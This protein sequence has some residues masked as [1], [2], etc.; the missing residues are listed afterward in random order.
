MGNFKSLDIN[1][2]LNDKLLAHL[3]S[4]PSLFLIMCQITLKVVNEELGRISIKLKVASYNGIVIICR[5]VYVCVISIEFYL[6]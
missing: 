1:K 4:R 2:L 5:Y 6:Q 3:K